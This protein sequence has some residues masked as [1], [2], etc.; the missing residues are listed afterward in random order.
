[1]NFIEIRNKM[2]AARVVKILLKDWK[3]DTPEYN[4]THRLYMKLIHPERE[5][6]KESVYNKN[7]IYKYRPETVRCLQRRAQESR[8]SRTKL[9]CILG[10]KC[11]QCG[12]EDLRALQIDHIN[13]GGR[14]DRLKI[15]SGQ[16]Y[17]FYINN[18]ELAKEKLQI[19]CANCNQIK[20]IEKREN[21]SDV[22]RLQQ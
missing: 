16:F 4:R 5:Q 17:R 12:F 15:S 6:E 21:G 20:R 3:W 1:M 18:P 7:R 11:V 10:T 22:A 19:L 2:I 14:Q 9:L 13:G 8:N